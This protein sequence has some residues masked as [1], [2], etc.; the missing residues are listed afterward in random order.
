M[1]PR[2]RLLRWCLPV[3]ALAMLGAGCSKSAAPTASPTSTPTSVS[4]GADGAAAKQHY[5]DTVNGLCDK[6]QTDV[7]RATQG[8]SIHIPVA[9]YLQDW[10]AHHALLV[11]FDKAVAAVPVPASAAS[12]AAALRAYTRYADRL[13]A[14]RLTAA[15]AGETAWTREV[16]AETSAA[17]DPSVAARTAAGFASSCDAR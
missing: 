12:A 9:Q 3:V 8:G 15:H 4:T 6:L 7:I 17:S 16:A 5:L 11:A 2:A 13:D 14:A 1:D 10:P